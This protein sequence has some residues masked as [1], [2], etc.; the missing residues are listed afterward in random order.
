MWPHQNAGGAGMP[1]T[2]GGIPPMMPGAYPVMPVA[3]GASGSAVASGSGAGGYDWGMAAQQWLKNKEMYEQWQQQQYQAHIQMMANA[4]RVAMASSI[5]LTVVNNPPPPP[6]IPPP[7]SGSTSEQSSYKTSLAE[8]SS[9]D[10]SSTTASTGASSSIA[11]MSKSKFKS[12]FSNSSLLKAVAAAVEAGENGASPGDVADASSSP[13]S[14]NK[15]KPLFPSYES[16]KVK[17]NEFF[18]YSQVFK[19]LYLFNIF[20]L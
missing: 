12:R 10:S 13:G 17:S 7:G 11:P 14:H 2:P 9:I 3:T 5:D 20:C 16:D 18:F 8:A 19:R 15:V 4:H 6:P 1:P